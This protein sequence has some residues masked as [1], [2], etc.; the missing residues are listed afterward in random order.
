M[1]MISEVIGT[2]R[3]GNAYARRITE[4]GSWGAR[5]PSFAGV[6]F[7]LVL[8]GTGW[9]VLRGGESIAL[10][11]GDVVLV[12]YGTEHGLSHTPCALGTLPVA[13]MGPEPPRPGPSDF[14]FLCGAYRLDNGK[15]H[16]FLRALPDVIAI[17]PDYDRHPQ[18]RS[19]AALL[20]DDVSEPRPGDEAT[21]SA[22]VDL[23]LV[24][25]LR[26]WQE[27]SGD[28]AWPRITDPGIAAAL[29]AIHDA[30]D[31]RWT[32]QRLSEIAGMS[33]TTF[34]RRFTDLLGKPPATYLT[35][36]RLTL[37]ARLLRETSAPLA[38]IARQVGYSTEFAFANAFRREYG[39]SPGRFRQNMRVAAAS[40]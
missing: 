37:G 19:L 5:Y 26:H 40:R 16:Q 21:R 27:Q 1:D 24:H 34:V 28:E 22:L 35:G 33:R 30:P 7:H 13:S 20:G 29:R 32:V 23:T 31:G 10:H 3:A 17:S 8:G 25:A 15:V 9:L 6:G 39:V 4:S 2:V 38:A 12:P 18:L 14:E 11:P 36:W